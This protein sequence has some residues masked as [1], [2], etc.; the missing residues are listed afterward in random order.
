MLFYSPEYVNKRLRLI[1]VEPL[2]GFEG[3][4]GSLEQI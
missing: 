2:R 1:L 3:I 4:D